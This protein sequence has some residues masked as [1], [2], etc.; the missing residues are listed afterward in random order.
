V[1][2]TGFWQRGEMVPLQWKL[3]EFSSINQWQLTLDEARLDNTL[4]TVIG[5][6]VGR[7][8]LNSIKQRSVPCFFPSL[9]FDFFSR[10]F[11]VLF[12]VAGKLICC[13]LGTQI[14]AALL[15]VGSRGM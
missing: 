10:I 9:F 15:S 2:N 12:V 6:F 5:R 7:A 14:L 4:Q 3:R 13:C 11:F 1:K 8:L